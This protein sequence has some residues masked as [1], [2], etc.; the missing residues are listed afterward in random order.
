[1]R[2]SVQIND[3]V[4]EVE[5]IERK[6]SAVTFKINDKSYSVALNSTTKV[7]S[8][9]AAHSTNKVTNEIV[10]PIP[11]VVADIKVNEGDSVKEGQV[12]VVL[13]AMKM[14]NN[15]HATRDGKIAKILIQKGQEVG[16]GIKLVEYV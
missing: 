5:V 8:S 14:E 4:L 3:K 2:Y 11:G 7:Q 1:M 16:L 10:A 6:G 9:K 15:I 13:E 12:V